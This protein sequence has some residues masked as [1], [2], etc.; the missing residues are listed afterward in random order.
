MDDNTLLLIILIGL[1]VTSGVLIVWYTL[2]NNRIQPHIRQGVSHRLGINMVRRRHLNG[3]HWQVEKP[4]PCLLSIG[5]L[6]NTLAD[7]MVVFLPIFCF[8][9]HSW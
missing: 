9:G 5:V 6:L 1:M 3:Y 2:Y 8:T 7:V 4:A